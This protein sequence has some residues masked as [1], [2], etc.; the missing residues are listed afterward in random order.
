M[1]HLVF[2]LLAVFA[3][4]PE[5]GHAQLTAESVVRF[6]VP[7]ANA[8]AV[9]IAL[10]ADTVLLGTINPEAY[11]FQ[12]DHGKWWM[13]R[14]VVPGVQQGSFSEVAIDEDVAF[15]GASP[16]AYVFRFDGATW[17]HEATLSDDGGDGDFG[18]SVDVDGNLAV[19][20]TRSKDVQVFRFDGLDWV[21]EARLAPAPS[22]NGKPPYGLA[23]YVVVDDE[24]VLVSKDSRIGDNFEGVYAFRF[25]GAQWRHEDTMTLSDTET[26]F[27]GAIALDGDV[28]LIDAD[29]DDVVYVFRFDGARWKREAILGP[30]ELDNRN[31]SCLPIPSGDRESCDGGTPNF[32]VSVALDGELALVG[33]NL[34]DVT[35][36]D[37]GAA[38]LYRYDG[39]R[40]NYELLLQ[41]EPTSSCGANFGRLVSFHDR[42]ALVRQG[43]SAIFFRIR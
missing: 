23:D 26:V 15:I 37:S 19:V 11:V 22:E 33:A 8:L 14:L 39:E 25:D 35:T 40:W 13:D 30:P 7:E 24:R 28:A 20:G 36:T 5:T 16:H 32:G 4:M 43:Q 1:R 34:D 42:R 27:I 3:L 12:F 41:G 21:R 31:C 9:S 29:Y 17:V 6:I 18:Y 10:H 2:S 38:Y